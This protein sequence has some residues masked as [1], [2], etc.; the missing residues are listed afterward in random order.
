MADGPLAGIGA[1]AGFGGAFATAGLTAAAAQSPLLAAPAI[2]VA[3]ALGSLARR[4]AL[5]AR[6]PTI[7]QLR[8]MNAGTVVITVT[9]LAA[10]IAGLPYAAHLIRH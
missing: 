6:F 9:M 2:L 7:G 10:V 5:R 4:P 1:V 8:T 3:L